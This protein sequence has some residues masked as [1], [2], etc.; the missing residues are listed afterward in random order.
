MYRK[1]V[2]ALLVGAA[3]GASPAAAQLVLELEA[4]DRAPVLGEPPAL[5]AV[6][7]NTGPGRARVN[8]HLGPEYDAVT[9]LITHPDGRTARAGT[10]AIKE[11]APLFAVLAP[12]EAVTDGVDLF[13]DGK[14]WVFDEPGT[15]VIHARYPGGV[16][17]EPLTLEVRAP[18]TAEQRRRA[19]LV[20]ATPEAG[21]FLLLKGGDHLEEGRTVLEQITRE[22]PDSVLA[23]HAAFALG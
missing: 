4:A 7:R 23:D 6:L 16:E 10:W 5:Q 11:P 17:A 8:P 19:E 12:G 13:F 9:Y 2:C 18:A 15:Y 1:Y 20:L 3:L 21:R 14:D 22:A